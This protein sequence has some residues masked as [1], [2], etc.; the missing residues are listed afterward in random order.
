MPPPPRQ[1]LPSVLLNSHYDVVPCMREHWD[2]DPFEAVWDKT[3]GRI[4]GRGTQDMKCV[5]IQYLLAIKRLQQKVRRCAC[6]RDVRPNLWPTRRVCCR[7]ELCPGHCMAVRCG[8]VTSGASRSDRSV[9]VHR[10]LDPDGLLGGAFSG[11]RR[12]SSY[13]S[14]DK[15]EDSLG[16][17]CVGPPGDDATAHRTW[18]H[19]RRS[20]RGSVPYNVQ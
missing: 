17:A 12:D 18:D 9:V 20:R 16:Y 10:R 6:A 1:D 5:C 4:Y 3:T 13:S 7:F 2:C 8:T 19:G 15:T 11:V 14:R